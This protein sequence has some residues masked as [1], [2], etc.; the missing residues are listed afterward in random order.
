MTTDRC[1]SKAPHLFSAEGPLKLVPG[2]RL[3]KAKIFVAF[4][5]SSRH[6]AE[7]YLEQTINLPKSSLIYYCLLILPFDLMYAK[8]HTA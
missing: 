7:Y 5:N 1:S 2:H 6:M 3:F 8:L 4:I